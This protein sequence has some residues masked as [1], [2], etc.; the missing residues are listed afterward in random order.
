MTNGTHFTCHSDIFQTEE[1]LKLAILLD[2]KAYC[3]H[4]G[5]FHKTADVFHSKSLE[6]PQRHPNLNIIK[7]PSVH[8][9]QNESPWGQHCVTHPQSDI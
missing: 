4:A 3:F 1:L 6:L 2:N 8:V 9:P 7:T 5:D